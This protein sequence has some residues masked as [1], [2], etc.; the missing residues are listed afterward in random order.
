MRSGTVGATEGWSPAVRRNRRAPEGKT[1]ALEVRPELAA[2]RAGRMLRVMDVHVE[3]AG[4]PLDRIDL[5]LRRAR[6]TL[7]LERRAERDVHRSCYARPPLVD[8]G[9]RPGPVD[10]RDGEVPA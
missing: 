6:A 2:H 9:R 3:R 8:V 10:L 7:A 1:P 5:G 4:V